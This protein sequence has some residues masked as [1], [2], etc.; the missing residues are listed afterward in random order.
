MGIDYE[1]YAAVAADPETLEREVRYRTSI[2]NKRI[3]LSIDRLDYSK[4]IPQRLKAFEMFLEK[5][6]QYL[7]AQLKLFRDG[8]RAND[9]NGM[10][11]GVAARMSDRE[12]RA[13]AE[14]AAGLR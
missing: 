9:P 13:A 14:Y 4:G 10:M 5:Y 7:E 8:A 1:R 6:P 2:G 3:I 11:R 12:I